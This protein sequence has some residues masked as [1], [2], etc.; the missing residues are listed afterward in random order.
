MVAGRSGW[1]H[2]IHYHPLVLGA[3]PAGAQRAL[4]VGCGAGMLARELREQVPCVMG[5][6]LDEPSLTAARAADPGGRVEYVLGDFRETGLKPESFDFI[7]CVAT[8]HHMDAV[9]ALR[10]MAALL[11][12]G[13]ALAVVGL[14]RIGSAADLPAEAAGVV[15]HRFELLRHEFAEATAPVL[16]PPPVT[17]GEMRRIAREELPGARFRRRALWRY[18]LTWQKPAA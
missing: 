10:R 1:N 16:W 17:Y 15:V 8:L 9:A 7:S 18:T 6:D 11:R 5:L 14:A 13:G 12:P 3:V 4:D 2:N